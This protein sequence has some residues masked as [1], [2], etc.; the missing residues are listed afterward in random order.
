[1]VVPRTKTKV[2]LSL[3]P[4]LVAA[5][6]ERVKG[7]RSLS[8]SGVIENLLRQW[9]EEEQQRQLEHET[10]TYYLSLTDEERQ[11]DRTWAELASNQAG[12]R[13]QDEE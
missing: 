13:W 5:V 6:D 10:E 9:Y 12:P 11:E 4:V 8:R 3:D 2:T 7:S 1:M